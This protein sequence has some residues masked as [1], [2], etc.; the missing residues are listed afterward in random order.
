MPIGN[1]CNLYYLWHFGLP[2]FARVSIW[3]IA[4]GNSLNISTG[5]VSSLRS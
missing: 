5:L 2:N 1:S 4:I 3:P